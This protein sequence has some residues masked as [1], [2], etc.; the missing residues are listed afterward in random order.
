[1]AHDLDGAIPTDAWKALETRLRQE[2]FRT[3]TY[4]WGE[5][6]GDALHVTFEEIEFSAF[7]GERTGVRELV[8]DYYTDARHRAL[9]P[10]AIVTAFEPFWRS[11]YSNRPHRIGGY[12]D[13]LQS[14]AQIGPA[15]QLLLFQIATDDAM[16]WCWGD[17]GAYY[18]FIEPG[19]LEERDFSKAV[20]TLECH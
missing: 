9:I 7:S 2:I 4:R 6:D 5:R 3:W 12:H 8:A 18:V 13:G 19:D 20:M 17:A 16:N 1:L 14:D 11:L 10:E 15:R